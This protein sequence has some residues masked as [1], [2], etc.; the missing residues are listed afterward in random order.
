VTNTTSVDR[1]DEG[2]TQTGQRTKPCPYCNEEVGAEEE[3]CPFCAESLNAEHT[4]SFAFVASSEQGVGE[5]ARRAGWLSAV[6]WALFLVASAVAVA[7]ASDRSSLLRTL[8]EERAELAYYRQ[9]YAAEVV[10]SSSLEAQVDQLSSR[11]R[12][13][14]AQIGDCEAAIS[15]YKRAMRAYSDMVAASS[16]GFYPLANYYYGQASR[17]FRQGDVAALSCTLAVGD[18]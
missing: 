4:E 6:P 18:L 15:A 12:G 9:R 11:V 14:T 13:L 7:L 2:T 17:A 5:Q 8:D 3:R 10:R 16:R 1:T